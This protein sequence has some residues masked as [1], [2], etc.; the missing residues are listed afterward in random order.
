MLGVLK[1]VVILHP[2]K[3]VVNVASFTNSKDLIKKTLEVLA[4]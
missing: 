2:Q 1:N 4:P 3:K